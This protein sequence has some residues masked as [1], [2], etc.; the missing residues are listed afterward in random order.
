MFE[1][2]WL[3]DPELFLQLFEKTECLAAEIPAPFTT[4]TKSSIRNTRKIRPTATPAPIRRR[5][6][7]RQRRRRTRWRW[8]VRYSPYRPR[9]P[10]RTTFNPTTVR[11][12]SPTGYVTPRLPRLRLQLNTKWW[13]AYR[14]SSRI[15]RPRRPQQQRQQRQRLQ[16]PPPICTTRTIPTKGC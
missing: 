12:P 16:R 5:P 4:C 10:P 9:D 2:T 6:L 1:K 14:T 8:T 11:H 15:R 13:P 7:R 3:F